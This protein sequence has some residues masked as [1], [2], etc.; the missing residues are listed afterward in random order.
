M[1]NMQKIWYILIYLHT[2][3]CKKA[4]PAVAEE[5]REQW[6]YSCPGGE[7]AT[8]KRR[9]RYHG[10]RKESEQFYLAGLKGQH[11]C[12]TGLHC[13][14]ESFP[15]WGHRNP[16]CDYHH[17]PECASENGEPWLCS[18]CWF[19]YQHN[20]CFWL[21]DLNSDFFGTNDRLWGE[22]DYL[23]CDQ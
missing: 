7:E 15:I 20:H 12:Q 4:L 17:Q 13:H 5:F 9:T 21:Q 18:K 23:S 1:Q 2:I 3:T 22:Q 10:I 6:Y 19:E 16:G 8:P 11:I 14:A